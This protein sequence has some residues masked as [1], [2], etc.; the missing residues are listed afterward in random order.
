MRSL[1][2]RGNLKR[3]IAEHRAI[4]RAASRGDTE[5]AVRLLIEHIHVPLR[6]LESASPQELDELGLAE[7]EPSKEAKG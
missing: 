6:R 2:L 4:L 7:R 3:S 5:R 1:A